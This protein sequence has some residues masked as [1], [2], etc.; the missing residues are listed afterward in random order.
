MLFLTTEIPNAVLGAGGCS[1]LMGIGIVDQ[2]AQ[3]KNID[4]IFMEVQKHLIG[5]LSPG[6]SGGVAISD[7]DLEA[8][9]IL[10]VTQIDFSD[11]ASNL[12]TSRITYFSGSV[13]SSAAFALPM[14]LQATAG[15]TSVC[16][17]SSK[18]GIRL[19]CC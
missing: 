8:A 14:L 18:R 10:G 17:R 9:K 19:C 5:S 15:S 12:S 3:G 13:G 11:N 7:A 16:R 1:K 6:S 2:G 4:L